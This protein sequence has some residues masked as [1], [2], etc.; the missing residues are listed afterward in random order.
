MEDFFFF[1]IACSVVVTVFVIYTIFVVISRKRNNPKDDTVNTNQNETKY[2][3]VIVDWRI[4][5]VEKNGNCLWSSDVVINDEHDMFLIGKSDD[6]DFQLIN[7]SG[8]SRN[9]AFIK[10]EKLDYYY[11]DSD[12]T[13]GS[14]YKGEFIKSI[15]IE[16]MMIIWISDMALLF[17]KYDEVN[18]ITPS[19]LNG[20]IQDEIKC[21]YAE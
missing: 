21:G 1:L 17:V 3:A 19:Y 14:K 4:Y 12:S 10:R 2:S 20:R 7:D 5:A 11:V 13:N 9:H 18:K 16:P 6:S 8:I 15:S